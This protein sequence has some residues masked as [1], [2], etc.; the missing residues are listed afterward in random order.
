MIWVFPIN[1]PLVKKITEPFIIFLRKGVLILS[2]KDKKEA[3]A[4][5][6]EMRIPRKTILY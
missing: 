4:I 3:G 6:F 1:S 5:Y 2:G